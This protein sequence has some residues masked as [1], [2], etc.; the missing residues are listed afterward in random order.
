MCGITGFI[1]GSRDQG[2]L[3]AMTQAISRRGPDDCGYFLEEGVGLGHRRLSIIDLSDCGH[4][5]MEFGTLVTV[6]NGEIYNYREVQ[7]ELAQL[8]YTFVSSSDTE[9]VLKAFHR[10]GPECVNRFI[11]MFAMAIYDRAERSLYLIRDRVGVKPLYWYE[12]AGR[13]AFG[14]ELRCFK[15]YLSAD[16]RARI[17]TPAVSQFMALGYISDDLSILADVKKVPQGHYIK[18]ANGQATVHRYWDVSFEENPG[19]AGRDEE[20]LLDE[21]ET[22]VISAFRYRMVADVPVGVFLSS[23]VDS[24]LVAAVLARHHGQLSTFTIGFEESGYDES[25][26]ARNIANHLG[27]RHSDAKLRPDK[28]FEILEH[29][30]DVYDEPHG[31]S[32]AIPTTFVSQIAR[33]GG[34]KVVLS[35]DGGDE[36]FGGYTRYQEFPRRWAQIQKGGTVGRRGAQAAFGLLAAVSPS[37]YAEKMGRFADILSRGNYSDFMQTIQRHLSVKDFNRLLPGFEDRLTA[38]A[39]GNRDIL[40]LMSEW[41]LKHYLPDDILVKVDRATMYHSIEGREPFLDHRLIEFAAQLPNRFKVRGGETKYLLKRLLGR[42]L[43]ERLYRLPKRGFGAPWATW[44]R[45]SFKQHFLRVLDEGV[46]EPFDRREVERLLE[47]YRRG[48]DVNYTIIWYLFSYHA[49]RRQWMATD[50]ART[51]GAD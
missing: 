27:T 49:W 23:G 20:D 36:L 41:D 14:S 10:W 24:S 34:A 38:P 2:V 22:L 44:T 40:S 50:D 48:E 28:A 26:D 43:P 3:Q 15:P 17:S 42:Y 4:Q 35:A 45:D 9:V 18:Y 12:K 47:R 51:L 7:A 33:E 31:D 21:L 8:G 29:L 13:L 6:F 19:W 46:A 39:G 1:D 37:A 25:P 5:P 30:Y 11:G 32:S 16:E